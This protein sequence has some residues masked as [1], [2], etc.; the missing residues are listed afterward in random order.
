MIMK[1]RMP[2]FTAELA[3]RDRG[4]VQFRRLG[5]PGLAYEVLAPQLFAPPHTFSCPWP[6]CIRDSHGD[7]ICFFNFF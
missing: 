1:M 6:P 5:R 7:C 2:G 3:I 4:R